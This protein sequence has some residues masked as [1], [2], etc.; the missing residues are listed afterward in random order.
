MA[1]AD[2]ER[3]LPKTT[4]G[5]LCKTQMPAGMRCATETRDLLSKAGTEF[6]Q[7]LA[8]ECLEIATAAK[9]SKIT[10]EHLEQACTSMGFAH[11]IPDIQSVGEQVDEVKVE[12]GKKWQ[13]SKTPEELLASQ[14]ALFAKAAA[15]NLALDHPP[16]APSPE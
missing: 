10:R 5:K 2:D 3:Q 6:V 7:M 15:N 9:K 16:S 12:R 14:R 8:S 1:D 11:Y 13:S 4:V